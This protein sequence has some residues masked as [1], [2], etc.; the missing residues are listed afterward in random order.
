MTEIL[1]FYSSIGPSVSAGSNQLLAGVA[2][3]MGLK[4]RPWRGESRNMKI[5]SANPPKMYNEQFSS[6][7]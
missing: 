5:N 4:R 7:P 1:L 2:E 3:A 6:W